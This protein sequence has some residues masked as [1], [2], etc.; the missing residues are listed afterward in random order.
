MWQCTFYSL[1]LLF[2]LCI[3]NSM[4]VLYPFSYDLSWCFINCFCLC[5]SVY[6]RFPKS[7]VRSLRR[8]ISE[9]A[10]LTHDSHL[11]PDQHVDFS[12]QLENHSFCWTLLNIDFVFQ[13]RSGSRH[14]NLEH[15]ILRHWVKNLFSIVVHVSNM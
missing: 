12:G 7:K 14:Y 8:S 6:V 1:T 13:L 5:F 11:T 9:A 3:N 2:S 4:E 10:L 15:V